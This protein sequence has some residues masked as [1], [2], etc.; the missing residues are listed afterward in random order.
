[1]TAYEDFNE[2]KSTYM[3][4]FF[5]HCGSLELWRHFVC[6]ILAE[7]SDEWVYRNDTFAKN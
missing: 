5:P 7:E 3:L 1:M 6:K 2:E 4:I